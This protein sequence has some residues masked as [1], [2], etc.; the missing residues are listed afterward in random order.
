MQNVFESIP[1]QQDRMGRREVIN[2]E[3]VQ[4]MQIALL[5]GQTVPVHK[6]NSTL[7]HLL[8]LTGGLAVDLDG[9]T[10][11]LKTG[12]ILPVA[13]GTP[14]QISNSGHEKTTFLAVKTPHPSR[15]RE[16]DS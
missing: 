16:D 10:Y 2:E 6:A 7:V 12:D 8:V 15:S 3:D 9:Q 1:Y 5:P 14:M 4:V 13:Y 11:S